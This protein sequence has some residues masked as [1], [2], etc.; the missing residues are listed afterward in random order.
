MK[1]RIFS[2]RLYSL[3]AVVLFLIY[4]CIGIVCYDDYGCGP[5]EGME[6]QTALVNFKYVIHKLNISI[7]EANE[8]WLG[9][10]PELHEYRDR[11][12]GTALHFPLVLIESFF[13]FTLEPAQFYGLRHFYTFVNYYFGVICLYKLLS[14]RFGSK[15]FGIIGMLMMIL[16]PRF[17]AESFYNN[18]DVIFVAWYAICLYLIDRW[19]RKRNLSNSVILAFSLALTCNTRFNGIIFIPVFIC[20]YIFDFLRNKNK[21]A[22]KYF[23]VVLFLSVIIFYLITP[24]F[25]EHPLQTLI[26]TL[27]FNMHHPNHGS[28]G[29][30]FKG[31]L[32]DAAQT[33]TYVPVWIIITT[34]V[35]YTLFILL[36]TLWSL[37]ELIQQV[38]RRDFRSI[39]L[40][41][42]AMLI[43]S[44]GAVF[45]IIFAHVTIYNGWR[46]CYFAYPCF[47]YFSVYLFSKLDNANYRPVKYV[48]AVALAVSMIYNIFWILRNHPFEYVY[49]SP[50][51]RSSANQFSGDYWGISSRALLEYITKIDPGRTITINHEFTQAGSINRGLLPLDK[52][53]LI[54]LVYEE[55]DA[56]EYYIICRDDIP[57]VS[58]NIPDFQK[59]Y[60]ITVDQDEFAAVYKRAP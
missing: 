41:D 60:S 28:D 45:F 13:H 53:D 48:C 30:L 24:N 27:Q 40:T 59:I 23:L 42:L 7:D 15:K 36:G 50:F 3:T 55:S 37:C 26:E 33:Y 11:Y 16:S 1:K 32:V 51:A 20:L 8:T 4:A 25:W 17:F 5:D 10:L 9:Y 14:S 18:K 22:L 38:L 12:Y 52:R 57:S 56:V 19:F 29:N 58:L 44:Y 43:V 35:I 2:E 31:V 21:A 34:P 39:R 47:V 54:E 49:F 46:H 6:R